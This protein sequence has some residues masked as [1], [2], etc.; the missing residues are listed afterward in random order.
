M[1]EILTGDHKAV[2]STANA[3]YSRS[4]HSSF[5][6]ILTILNIYIGL[7]QTQTVECDYSSSDKVSY[8]RRR[9]TVYRHNRS[10]DH[11]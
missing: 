7:L 8:L 5:I 6:T 11:R 1:D 9:L 10:F 2:K 4:V 3:I